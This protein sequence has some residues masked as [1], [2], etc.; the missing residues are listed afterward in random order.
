LKE[1]STGFVVLYANENH[2]A[3]FIA[4]EHDGDDIFECTHLHSYPFALMEQAMASKNT[5]SHNSQPSHVMKRWLAARW[6]EIG[7]FSFNRNNRIHN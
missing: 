1:A 5:K 3:L 2:R 7:E 4:N 6:G